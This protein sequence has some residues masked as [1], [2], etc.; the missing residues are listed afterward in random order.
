MGF[1]D[2]LFGKQAATRVETTPD[3]IWLTTAAK[4][5]GVS[6]AVER[7][8]RSE[9]IALMLV[10]HFPDVLSTLD[11]I[12]DQHNQGKP[13]RACLASNLDA[14]LAKSLRLGE[15]AILDVIVAERHPM[16]SMDEQLLEFAQ[17]LPCRCRLSHHLSLED[18]LMEAFTGAWIQEALSSLGMR[19]DEAIQSS[20]VSRRIRQAQKKF[21]QRANGRLEANSAAEWIQLNCS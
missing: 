11:D 7:R 4:Y 17:Q 12:A 18:A 3:S 16:R 20:M 15:S 6:A 9:S 5:K 21:E 13:V 8:D 19:E 2:L 14:D 10:A 1:F